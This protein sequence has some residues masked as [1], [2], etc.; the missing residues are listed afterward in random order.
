MRLT[1]AALL[2][3]TSAGIALAQT[4]TPGTSTAPG[5][6][7]SAAT[8]TGPGAT[9]AERPRTQ[10]NVPATTPGGPKASESRGPDPARPTRPTNPDKQDPS[11]KCARNGGRGAVQL[12]PQASSSLDLQSSICRQPRSP[13]LIPPALVPAMRASFCGGHDRCRSRGARFGFASTS[14]RSRSVRAR[15]GAG[16]VGRSVCVQRLRNPRQSGA[17]QTSEASLDFVGR[18]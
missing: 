16:S 5:S 1:I 8:G 10:G 2:L 18:A 9:P 17:Y 12:I 13:G 3:A 6:S 4:T 7:G 15:G 11:P 14:R